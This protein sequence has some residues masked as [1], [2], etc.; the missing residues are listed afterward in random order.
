[1]AGRESG[2][3][4]A[5]RIRRLFVQADN[6]QRKNWRKREQQGYDF[7]LN[8]QLTKDQISDLENSGMPTF[9]INM[10]TPIIEIMKY[11][12]TA[13]NPRWNAIGRE[14]SDTD[15]A[16]IHSAL[17]EY[18]W[19]ISSGR[20]VFSQI[21]DD[22]LRK[23]RGYMHLYV[24]P[25][26]D[27]GMG[28]VM[29]D[30]VSPWD[31]YENPTGRDIF[32]RDRNFK[33]I[34]K[35]LTRST[36][37][38]KLP[39]F[40]LKIQKAQG[41]QDSNFYSERDMDESASI[42]AEDISVGI[43]S[44]GREEDLISYYECY[45]KVPIPF[46][47]VFIKFPPSDAEMAKAKKII[48]VQIMELKKEL[49]VQ[50][51]EKKTEMAKLV[52]EGKA[53][54][55]RA[56]LEVERAQQRMVEAVNQKQ[57]ILYSK[58]RDEK[59]RIEDKTVT[60]DEFKI[61]SQNEKFM[62]NVVS[63]H[64]FYENRIKQTCV[65]GDTVLYEKMVDIKDYP[66]I[67]LPY[68]HTGT[69]YSMS[70]VT[71]LVGKQQ[72]INK[73]H[74]ITIHNANLGSNIRWLVQEGQVNKAD[75][76]MYSSSAG[77]ILTWN[78]VAG[79]GSAPQAILPM[80]LSNAFFTLTQSG[81]GDMEY[82]SGISSSMMGMQDKERE[83]YR[84]MLAQDEFGT[85]RL[86]NWINNV[87]EPFLE[88][89]GVVFQELAQKH[90]TAKKVFRIIQPNPDG[91]HGTVDQEMNIPIYNNFGDVIGRF[92]DYAS[93]RFD[94]RIVPGST[95]PVNRWALIEEYFKWYQAQ[96]I[97]DIAMLA[98]TDIKNKDQIIKRK[99]L[100]AK[101]ENQINQLKEALKNEQGT[102]ETLQRQ[103]I[104][105]KIDVEVL[106]VGSEMRKDLVDTKG[107]I[108]SIV[109]DLK[110]NAEYQ[111]KKVQDDNKK[112]TKNEENK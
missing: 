11:F 8:D 6:P 9:I 45:E 62:E 110:L 63:T 106:R 86:K 42:Q 61:M 92:K 89:V 76:E 49:S 41:E 90:Y 31:V 2:K 36:I 59:S 87:L 10:I 40:K 7:S 19:Y 60:A 39:A 65:V 12:L 94:V 4:K 102:V 52:K 18:C 67:S 33:M 83:T 47:R 55:E 37:I 99:S 70:A 75:W 66:L 27:R 46:V 44:E 56:K 96:L 58:A 21:V 23:S 13:K 17:I 53:I 22:T 69:P 101:M 85:R 48:D 84:G 81:K 24:D 73:A 20:Q 107:E 72:E 80:S 15:I 111:K 91:G 5:E 109:T 28:E 88:H 64:D 108:G 26:E 79:N 71:P 74:Q 35:N 104:Q 105:K 93:A 14:G 77:A 16:A 30:F 68:T 103:V 43:D 54:P 98:E 78:D 97:D 29:F 82:Q 32:G 25:N 3:K 38:Q 50:I 34:K 112:I 57:Q 51:E 100:Y 1:M 95:M